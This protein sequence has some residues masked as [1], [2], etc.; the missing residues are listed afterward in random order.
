MSN[1]WKKIESSAGTSYLEKEFIFK[2]F[3]EA[4]TAMQKIA[5]LAEKLHHHP[6]LINTYNRVKINLSTHD[7]GNIIGKKD[8]LL[9][10][11]IDKVLE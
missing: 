1:N 10:E 5:F 3:V 6:T 2:N 7:E 4:F 11:E 9:A 8:Y